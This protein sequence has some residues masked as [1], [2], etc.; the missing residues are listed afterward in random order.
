M[1][2]LVRNPQAEIAASKL[3]TQALLEML[4]R[5]LATPPVESEPATEESRAA[6]G[7]SCPKCN[8]PTTHQAKFCS[9]CGHKLETT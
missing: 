6:T 9:N 1:N 2:G 5:E 4:R 7:K 8:Y 3:A